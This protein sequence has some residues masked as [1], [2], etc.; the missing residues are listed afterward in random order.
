[1]ARK[2]SRDQWRNKPKQ[3]RKKTRKMPEAVKQELAENKAEKK[4]GEDDRYMERFRRSQ[5]LHQRALTT[6]RRRTQ[7]LI[8][9]HFHEVYGEVWREVKEGLRQHAEEQMA[10]D[11]ANR[12]AQGW[13]EEE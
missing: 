12:E 9:N 6:S 2:R 5:V 10:V 3:R 13:E 1:M 7:G 11:R 4:T 8:D